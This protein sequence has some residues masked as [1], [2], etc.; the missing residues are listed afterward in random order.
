MALK[1][2]VTHVQTFRRRPAFRQEA[3]DPMLCI[4]SSHLQFANGAV[5]Y[6]VL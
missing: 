4:N 1:G 5:G 2:G 3:A 6:R